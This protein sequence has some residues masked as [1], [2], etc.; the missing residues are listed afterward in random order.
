ML[1]FLKTIIKPIIFNRKLSAT[2]RLIYYT[3]REI[4]A[5]T[6]KD[7]FSVEMIARCS[8]L[9]RGTVSRNLP[10]L[11]K[12]GYVQV[13]RAGRNSGECSRY[14]VSETHSGVSETHTK[15]VS[16]KDSESVT[17]QPKQNLCAPVTHPPASGG[18]DGLKQQYGDYRVDAVMAYAK[19]ETTI[20]N[21]MVFA[22]SVLEG[23]CKTVDVDALEQA[24]RRSQSGPD[25]TAGKYGQYVVS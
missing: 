4:I 6:G 22:R 13:D 16:Y 14:R 15:V 1:S 17:N 18:I 3:I 23:R 11:E 21:P 25:Y 20:R 8:D 24:H 19:S 10:A 12:A 7:K 5:V 2:Q 9:S